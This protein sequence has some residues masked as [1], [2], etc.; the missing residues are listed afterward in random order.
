MELNLCPFSSLLWRETRAFVSSQRATD[1]RSEAHRHT[2]FSQETN[3]G[4]L[5]VTRACHSAGALKKEMARAHMQSL[6]L[7]RAFCLRVSLVH[8]FISL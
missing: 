2:F 3:P 8:L 1:G 6:A 5:D 7:A 4:S